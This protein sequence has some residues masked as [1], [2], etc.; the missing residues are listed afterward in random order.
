MSV[1]KSP[2]FYF[3]V[4]LV[5]VVS[6]A[7]AAPYVVPW[8]NYR[9]DLE[10][11]GRKIT[12][13]EVSIG[14]DIAVTLFPWPQ[15]EARQ[16]AIGN[17]A[18]FAESDFVQADVV[19]M[20]LS[21]AGLF[22]G[23]P[24]VESIE[25]ERPQVNLQRN[26]SGDVNWIFAPMEQVLGAGLLSRV[27]L[28]QIT[29]QN[30]SI[31]YDDFR[32]GHATSFS[33]LNATLAADSVLGPWRMR[34]GTKWGET[35][36]SLSITSSVKQ[37][38]KPLQFA[39]KVIPLDAAL[40]Q[41]G[42]DGAWDG[43]SF[44]G[45]LRF[46]PQNAGDGKASAE[47]AF[48][49]LSMQSDL[50]VN[51]SRLSLLKIRITPADRKDN[52]TLIEGDAVVEF[53]TQ[54][55][56][57]LELK[58]PRINLDTLVG[59]GAMQQWRDG[60]LLLTANHILANL[61]PSLVA[62]YKLTVNVLTSGGQ[63]LNDVRLAGSVQKEAIRVKEFAAEMPG[64]SAGVFDGILFPGEKAA[65]L[66]GKFKFESGDAR[67]F[68]SWL[69]PTWRT[70]IEK[71]WT[72]SRG[73]L[74][75]ESG[76]LD[77]NA[78]GIAFSNVAYQLD[79]APGTASWSS[80]TA[81]AP[82]LDVTVNVA[83]LDLDSLVPNGWSLLRDGGLP[84]VA[85]LVT[86]ANASKVQE[87]RFSLQ[88]DSVLQNG[89]SAQNISLNFVAAAD[90]FK[91]KLLDIGNVGGAR[92]V[93]GGDVV[94]QG[95]GPEGTLDFKLTAQ[96]PRGFLRLVGLDFGTSRWTES[97]R[98]T[99]LLA[100]V[101]ATPQKSGP[102]ILIEARGNSGALDME[103]VSTLREFEKG[104][105]AIVAAS[106]GL[107]SQDGAALARLVGVVPVAAVGPGDVS[108]ELKGSY[109]D[110]FVFATT[111]K[112]LDANMKLEG[113]AQ[114]SQPYLGLAAKF[115][116]TANDGRPLLVATGLPL[117]TTV[118]QPLQLAATLAARDGG[119]AF[120]DVSGN[121]D[122]R[123]VTGTGELTSVGRMQVDVET[124][125]LDVRE[126]AALAFMPWNGPAIDLSQSFAEV[127][128]AVLGEVFIRPLQFDPGTG[129]PQKEVVI[130]IGF[131]AGERRLN[132]VAP[133]EQGLK[134]DVVLVPK[135][136]SNEFS[137]DLRWPLDLSTLIA[138]TDGS[139][140]LTGS[141]IVQGA[142]KAN[143]R[144]AAAAFAGLE[145]QGH[146]FLNGAKLARMTLGGFS[147]SI[148]DAKTPDALTAVL[149]KMDGAPGTRVGERIGTI[150]ASA[151]L[152][153]FSPVDVVVQGLKAVVTSQFDVTA[154]QT[155]VSTAV[156]LLEPTGLPP[157]TIT[158]SGPAGAMSVRNGTSAL[159]AKLG[160]DLLSKEM[161]E[162][163]KLQNEQQ[164]LIA[165]EEAQRA[166][167]EKRFADYQSTRLELREQARVRKFHKAERDRMQAVWRR[168][169]D[170]AIANGAVATRLELQRHAR[171]IA[172][173][174][175]VAGP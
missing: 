51:G 116:A 168:M 7:L 165:K 140:L 169:A 174:R 90:G 172:V 36:V 154:M 93:G 82:V 99:E 46:D 58:S 152:L 164:A 118:A 2:V 24:N 25:V 128:P 1:W 72:G 60:G 105:G 44:T 106:G 9:T 135:N 109:T 32:N 81:P 158:Y 73:R 33:A 162:L 125:L 18:G 54:S 112:A 5:L 14:G 79:G 124:D 22:S 68:L 48:K 31:S 87:T 126:A 145:G 11:Y 69:L 121:I 19:R 57:R 161:A 80:N 119:L 136:A 129:T 153:T 4:L 159:A 65:Q 155:T 141:M 167:D 97:L 38:G 160:Y 156:Q 171:R 28:D 127:P 173:R 29:L 91:L 101:I 13:R 110:G 64:R 92:L 150:T 143:G 53:G 67:A 61:P 41:A 88:A 74:Q 23:T 3:G 132:I 149:Q 59:A 98:Q 40:P 157:V 130:G 108:F 85:A 117:S 12:G 151:G 103:L 70:E 27:K 104:M 115:N 52:G 76:T 34:G 43:K 139:P 114:P 42:V 26:A 77:W 89:V 131:E 56:A 170:D 63:A 138:T 6:A 78:A 166:D 163:E 102:E 8:N 75:V 16:V 55:V 107:R 86:R 10:S 120:L 94:D 122:G 39:V 62:D 45:Q 146:Y 96:D 47:G 21:L 113:T 123:R 84:G 30:G 66:G 17:P 49:P 71:H 20:R 137:A 111:V 134:A 133:G 95:N 83:K 50:D 100:K 147:K 37:T 15:L 175:A 142:F 144:N 148:S 35:P